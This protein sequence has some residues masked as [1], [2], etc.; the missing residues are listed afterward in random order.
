MN[1]S[2]T[3]TLYKKK[4]T[5]VIYK[6]HLGMVNG[7]GLFNSVNLLNLSSVNKAFV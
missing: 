6:Q 3:C 5:M 4:K 1:Y 7:Y 2:F